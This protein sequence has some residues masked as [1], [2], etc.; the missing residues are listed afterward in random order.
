MLGLS[1]REEHGRAN[2]K[3]LS[4]KGGSTAQPSPEEMLHATSPKELRR[5]MELCIPRKRYLYNNIILL[6]TRK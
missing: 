1:P 5:K 6:P 3:G 4:N 2:Y